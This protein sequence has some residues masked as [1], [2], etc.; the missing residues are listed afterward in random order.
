ME[1]KHIQNVQTRM[2]KADMKQA[3]FLVILGETVSSVNIIH[4]QF[5]KMVEING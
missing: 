1:K 3:R 4:A 5:R 2:E